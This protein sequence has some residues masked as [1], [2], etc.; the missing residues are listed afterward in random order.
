MKALLAGP[1]PWLASSGAVVTAFPEDTQLVAETV[2]ITGTSASVDITGNALN[3]TLEQKRLMLRQAAASLSSL[4][5]IFTVQLSIAG[6]PQDISAQSEDVQ[7]GYP[8]V[9]ARPLVIADTKFG[10]LA[11]SG[12][13][14]EIP[15][16]SPVVST[17][18]PWSAAYSD[19][20]NAAALNVDEGVMLVRSTGSATLIDARSDLAPAVF[21]YYGFVWSVPRDKP[22]DLLATT[23]S[24]VK[25]LVEN[26]WPADGR[27]V[28]MSIS[29]DGA[30]IAAL[31]ETGGVTKLLVSGISRDGQNGPVAVGEPLI[32]S[33]KS[34][35][36]TSAVW[37]DPLTVGVLTT[38]GDGRSALSL[39]TIGGGVRPIT[40]SSSG[41]SLSAGNSV[42]EVYMRSAENELFSYRGSGTWPMVARN[43]QVQV[44]VQ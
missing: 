6:V 10:Y 41:V 26:V 13:I 15:E 37:V 23:T 4:S 24:G 33:V 5:S 9:N 43:V 27:V 12:V 20:H 1:S 44:Q 35:N 7:K 40:P 36:S 39:N 21:D 30:R 31:L 8:Q 17:F 14:E 3:S 2:P 19:V 38:L 42:S 22:R 28:S 18:T 29:R 34:G 32:L 11:P 25:R 16:I